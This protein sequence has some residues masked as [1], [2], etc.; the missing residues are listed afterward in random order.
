MVWPDNKGVA[1]G[2]RKP[3]QASMW[4][5]TSRLQARG[6]HPFYARLNE[7]LDQ[8][9]FD[10]YGERICRKYYARTMG[11]PLLSDGRGIAYRLSDS[12]SLRGFLGL[13]LEE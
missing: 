4:V 11:R 1:L 9:K 7:I 6:R 2:K 5:E 10:F 3:K 8:A 13:S 12:L